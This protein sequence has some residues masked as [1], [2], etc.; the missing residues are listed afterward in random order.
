MGPLQIA[1]GAHVAMT[2]PNFYRLE[3]AVSFIP[4]Y[5]ACLRERLAFDGEV[6]RVSDRPGLGHDLDVEVLRRHPA[7]GWTNEPE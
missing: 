2:V 7:K 5:Q 6:V 1:A 4:F 3:H